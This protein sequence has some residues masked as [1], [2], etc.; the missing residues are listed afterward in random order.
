MDVEKDGYCLT[1]DIISAFA[2]REQQKLDKNLKQGRWCPGEDSTQL[3]LQ[4]GSAVLI[5]E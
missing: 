1:L 5:L 3:H 4:Y 2:Q